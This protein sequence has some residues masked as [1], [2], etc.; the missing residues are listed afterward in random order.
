MRL[1]YRELFVYLISGNPQVLFNPVSDILFTA[2]ENYD[3]IWAT[4]I[5]YYTGIR[6][7]KLSQFSWE[8]VMITNISGTILE[9][10]SQDMI[11]A[12]IFI[13]IFCNSVFYK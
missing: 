13:E 10:V 6:Q 2:M 11:I 8:S 4:N 1:I 12:Y 5:Q 9:A 7:L 3:S